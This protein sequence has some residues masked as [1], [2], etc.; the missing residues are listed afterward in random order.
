MLCGFDDSPESRKMFPTLTTVHI[1]TQI[2]A[3]SATQLLIS[4][5]EE[6]SLDFRRVY[7]ATDLVIRESTGKVLEEASL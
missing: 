3:F 2:I 7:T 6:P 4:R 1:H 5:I